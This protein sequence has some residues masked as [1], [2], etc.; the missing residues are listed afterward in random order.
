MSEQNWVCLR[1]R[2]QKEFAAQRYLEQLGYN[3]YLPTETVKRNGGGVRRRVCDITRP[4]IVGYLFVAVPDHPDWLE[5]NYRYYI[6][7]A[8]GHQGCPWYF[9]NT[10]MRRL[11][12]R[13]HT[14]VSHMRCNDR[15]FGR[16]LA[17]FD[18]GDNANITV[19]P[20]AGNQIKII[21]VKGYRF[22]GEMEAFGGTVPIEGDIVDLEAA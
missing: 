20:F 1:S 15:R 13:W 2:T 9:T 10:F 19:G 14:G 7:G 22:K 4:F 16:E 12:W 18:I 3:V 5:I 8:I 6:A 11:R 21:S 17:R